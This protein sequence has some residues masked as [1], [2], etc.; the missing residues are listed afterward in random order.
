MLNFRELYIYTGGVLFHREWCIR[1]LWCSSIISLNIISIAYNHY[2]DFYPLFLKTLTH[3]NRG[4]RSYWG[5]KNWFRRYRSSGSKEHVKG[6]FRR[7][8]LVGGAR[9]LCI[10]RGFVDSYCSILLLSCFMWSGALENRKPA[11]VFLVFFLLS[12]SLII[13][14]LHSTIMLIALWRDWTI[15]AISLLYAPNDTVHTL[16]ETLIIT[17]PPFF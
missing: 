2:T 10:V 5:H 1:Q 8:W 14:S 13:I 17:H 3:T 11:L 4:W 15:T 12:C 6:D 9:R 16:D 7:R